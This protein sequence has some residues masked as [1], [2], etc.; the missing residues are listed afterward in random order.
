MYLTLTGQ[1]TRSQKV[2]KLKSVKANE[3]LREHGIEWIDGAYVFLLEKIAILM[4]GQARPVDPRLIAAILV[5]E[6]DIDTTHEEAINDMPKGWYA[7]LGGFLD[8]DEEE[9]FDESWEEAVFKAVEGMK[10]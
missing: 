3:V 9:S 5:E 2:N 1:I 6:F 4:G 8:P 10:E 7:W